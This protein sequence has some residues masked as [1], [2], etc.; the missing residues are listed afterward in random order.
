MPTA[1][2]LMTGSELLSGDIADTNSQFL[3]QQ[4]SEYPIELVEKLT[5]GD[6]LSILQSNI[7]RL[8]SN[9][10]VLII[11]GGLGPTTDDLTAQALANSAKL[12]LCIQAQALVHLQKWG[13]ARNFVIDEQQKKQ[14]L[15][16]GGAQIFPSSPGSACGFYL[17]LNNCLIITT[18]G[19]PSE[20]KT[21]I[22]ED[23]LPKLYELLGQQPT[24]S[25]QRFHYFGL[26]ES[27][28]QSL[29][30]EQFPK[31]YEYY[32][33]GFRAQLAQVELKLKPIDSS[34]CPAAINEKR[35]CCEALSEF[36]VARNGHDIIDTL[37]NLLIDA[38][39]NLGLAESCTGG[40]IAS[41]I[42]RKAGS[43]SYFSGGIVS[44]SNEVKSSQLKVSASTLEQHGA[45]SAQCA[46]EMLNGVFLELKTDYGIAVTGIAGPT[47]GSEEKPLGTVYIAYGSP[48]DIS[49]MGLVIPFPRQAF[50]DI[51]SQIALDGIRRKLQGLGENERMFKRYAIMEYSK[52]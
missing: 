49:I 21:I 50:Q 26:G 14:C 1:A 5:V 28:L 17:N 43:S 29:I 20:M 44:Y 2:L 13:N 36:E 7:E 35:A 27:S 8:S 32:E 40:L 30:Q 46:R 12:E 34:E 41:R 38:G 23:V 25:W 6:D 10:D 11:N 48:D 24:A 16:P 52:S 33:V 18:P 37:A 19:V 39:K 47:G 51:V 4:L 31:L 22:C 9:H 3:A 42:T 15:L 45:V